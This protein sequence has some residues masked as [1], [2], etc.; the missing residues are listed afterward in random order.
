[1]AQSFNLKSYLNMTLS[2]SYINGE[3]CLGSVKDSKKDTIYVFISPESKEKFITELHA[4]TKKPAQVLR[5]MFSKR[6]GSLYLKNIQNMYGK[7][8]ETIEECIVDGYGSVDKFLKQIGF[9]KK[10]GGKG[11][12][13]KMNLF[14]ANFDEPRDPFADKDYSAVRQKSVEVVERVEVVNSNTIGDSGRGLKTEPTVE[15]PNKIEEDIIVADVN[16]DLV[17]GFSDL[18]DDLEE[19]DKEVIEAVEN[20]DDGITLEDIP[21]VVEENVT[22]EKQAVEVIPIPQLEI[23]SSIIPKPTLVQKPIEPE[24]Q[25]VI[26][27]VTEVEDTNTEVVEEKQIETEVSNDEEQSVVIEEIIEENIIKESEVRDD[28]VESAQQDIVEEKED[29][30]T[31]TEQSDVVTGDEIEEQEQSEEQLQE[32]AEEL[33]VV[34]EVTVQKE[35]VNNK[36]YDEPQQYNMNVQQFPQ[37]FNPNQQYQN[38]LINHL[39]QGIFAASANAV[40]MQQLENMFMACATPEQ[41]EEYNKKMFI[42][43]EEDLEEFIDSLPKLDKDAVIKALGKTLSRRWRDG[44]S[45]AVSVF[46]EV[47][48]D[49]LS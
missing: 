41:I 11:D 5:D 37:Q 39:S 49:F 12:S 28:I 17:D 42:K 44:D 47:M 48:L 43:T 34:E 2:A 3:E 18:L 46:V 10:N 24:V 25:D 36:N 4:K 23:V 1:M 21:E 35:D 6:P 30:D 29:G 31:T 19:E 26:E 20:V 13:S 45:K 40:Y 9:I 38:D 27:P 7:K 16:E 33:E 8:Y 32:Q 14:G 22:D 15:S